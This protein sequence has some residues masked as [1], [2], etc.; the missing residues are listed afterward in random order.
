MIRT[1]LRLFRKYSQV[2]KLG[3]GC[4]KG[5]EVSS[6]SVCVQTISL[7][8]RQEKKK[9][10]ERARAFNWIVFEMDLSGDSR[11]SWTFNAQLSIF[12]VFHFN[13]SIQLDDSMLI[14]VSQRSNLSSHNSLLHCIW[15]E[16]GCV[17]HSSKLMFRM[18][19]NC[20]LSTKLCKIWKATISTCAASSSQWITVLLRLQWQAI[21]SLMIYAV[22]IITIIFQRGR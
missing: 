5:A 19:R 9:R 3:H 7:I 1:F 20:C 2:W 21:S 18:A 13:K 4:L 11:S 12:L 15:D 8:I 10:L 14:L 17:V 6:F 16:I 22:S